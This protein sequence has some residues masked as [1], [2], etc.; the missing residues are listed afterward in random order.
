MRI[1]LQVALLIFLT[2]GN[3]AADRVKRRSVRAL[4]HPSNNAKLIDD[5]ELSMRTEN[6]GGFHN[7]DK[8]IQANDNDSCDPIQATSDIFQNATIASSGSVTYQANTDVTG[9]LSFDKTQGYYADLDA[10]QDDL[11]GTN[12]SVF[13]WVKSKG[14]TTNFEVLFAVNRVGAGAPYTT[15]YIH[16]DGDQ[17]H[18]NAQNAVFQNSFA[19]MSDNE[20]H[21][22]G[23]TY[24]TT[25]HLTSIYVDGALTTTFTRDQ[26]TTADSRYSLGQEFSGTSENFHFNGDMAEVSVWDEVLTESDVRQA[27]QQKIDNSHPKHANLKGYYSVFGACDDDPAVLKDY[28]G[29]SN[30]GIMRN[31]FTQDFKNVQSIPGFNAVGWYDNLSWKKDDVEVATTETFTPNLEEG[32][33]EFSATGQLNEKA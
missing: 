5:Y 13:M 16:R 2:F 32:T 26:Q 12:R 3:N 1:I 20:W 31:S 7:D 33:Y 25:T 30:D 18:V 15:L 9:V 24:N 19:D 8:R 4:H 28:S 11:N 23:Y 21:Y 10:L 27:M 29:N 14:N 22:V 6:I 17:I